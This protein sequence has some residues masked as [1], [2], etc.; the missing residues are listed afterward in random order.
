MKNKSFALFSLFLLLIS[1]ANVFAQAQNTSN[2]DALN[3]PRISGKDKKAK[4][5]VN[6]FEL[7]RLA[8]ELINKERAANNLKELTWNED[9]A[10]VARLHSQNMVSGGF[11]NHRGL[12]GSMVNDRADSLGVS[13][14]QAIGENIAYNRGYENPTE[15]AVECWMQS[16]SHRENILSERWKETG[17]G[18][19]VAADDSYYFTQVFLLRR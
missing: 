12:D 6:I 16:N 4:K 8:F 13:K 11:F 1:A 5:T 3:R 18:I 19:A 15:F 14:W 2:I 10:K 17:V 7:E 9:V